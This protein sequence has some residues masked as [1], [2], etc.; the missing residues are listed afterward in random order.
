MVSPVNTSI[1]QPAGYFPALTGVRAVAACMIFAQHYRPKAGQ[2]PEILDLILYTFHVALPAF[3]VLSGFLITYRYETAF[4]N[5]TIR[6]SKYMLLRFARIYPLYLTLIIIVLIWQKNDSAWEWFLNLTLLKSF[7]DAEKFTGIAQA[8][9]ITVEEVF[10]FSAPLLFLGFRKLRIVA[11]F[12]VLLIGIGL[13]MLSQQ[14]GGLSFMNNFPFMMEYTFFGRCFEFYCGYRLAVYLKH[15]PDMDKKGSFF[16]VTGVLAALAAFSLVAYAHTRKFTFPFPATP[17]NLANN[18]VLP[19]GIALLFYGLVTEKTFFSRFLSLKPV[20]VFGK[21][22]YAFY[23]IHAG[24]FYK[25]IYFNITTNKFFSFLL[26]GAAA[27]AIFLL[28]EEPVNQYIRRKL[29]ARELRKKIKQ[30]PDFLRQ[31]A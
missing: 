3:F 31:K 4:Q 9:S 13:V 24:V 29:D 19:I 14:G 28:F 6:F 18:F 21:S 23:L 5:G 27:V 17:E 22:S 1:N 8:W 30:Q 25:F 11:V 7:F 16:T 10:Y 26:I 15:N 12:L 20:Q 2:L